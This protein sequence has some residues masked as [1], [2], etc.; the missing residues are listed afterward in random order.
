[1]QKV[2]EREV[3]EQ[4]SVIEGDEILGQYFESLLSKNGFRTL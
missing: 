2:A 3:T 4:A 1:M